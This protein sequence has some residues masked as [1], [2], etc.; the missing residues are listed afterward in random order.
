MVENSPSETTDESR[1]VTVTVYIVPDIVTVTNLTARGTLSPPT[2]SPPPTLRPPT[3]SPP[4]PTPPLR[5]SYSKYFLAVTRCYPG[6]LV[7]QCH[8][9]QLLIEYCHISICTNQG[10]R[11]LSRSL[12]WMISVITGKHRLISLNQEGEWGNFLSSR[13]VPTF[14]VEIENTYIFF[15]SINKGHPVQNKEL[16][17][18]VKIVIC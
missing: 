15:L 6:P 4:P 10:W 18:F 13:N 3:S 17:L 9:C 7:L 11:V 2:P 14:I 8:T 16:L 1:E 12:S 5:Q